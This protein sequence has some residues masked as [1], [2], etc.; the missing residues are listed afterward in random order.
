[1]LAQLS[2]S[3]ATSAH[4]R[5]SRRLFVFRFY[6]YLFLISRRPPKDTLFPYTTLFRSEW[7]DNLPNRGHR[8]WRPA[9]MSPYPRFVGK[10]TSSRSEEHTS[11]LQSRFD[12]VC[13]LLLDNKI[14][15][16]AFVRTTNRSSIGDW[17]RICCCQ[18]S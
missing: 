1:P 17:L 4:S 3:Y 10:L 11:E 9:M 12:L 2:V 8:I 15:D 7:Q 6:L 5:P 13:R 16:I 18:S 14:S